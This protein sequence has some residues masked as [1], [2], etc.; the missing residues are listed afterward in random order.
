MN[1]EII[2][3]KNRSKIQRALTKISR[4]LRAL[5]T[6]QLTRNIEALNED[7]KEINQLA[8]MEIPMLVG[9]YII[10]EVIKEIK[11]ICNAVTKVQKLE[12]DQFKRSTIQNYIEQRYENF[13]SNTRKM[14]S[15][16]LKR[17]RDPVVLNNI[18]LH[19]D[20][21][22]TPEQNTPSLTKDEIDIENQ[23]KLIKN[24]I[25]GRITIILSLIII[26]LSF[27]ITGVGII[28]GWKNKIDIVVENTI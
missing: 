21:I 14:I 20:I 13:S 4:L 8:N 26:G 19:N 15:S 10:E 18:K 6:K 2:Y 17:T 12:N 16:I 22:T 3:K 28:F 5:C 27:Y 9:E 1:R 23:N 25:E 24:K 11:I 7:I